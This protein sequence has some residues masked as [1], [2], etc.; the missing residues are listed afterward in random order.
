MA[1]RQC[2]LHHSVTCIWL[3]N[4]L[5]PQGTTKLLVLLLNAKCEDWDGPPAWVLSCKIFCMFSL[6]PH[7]ELEWDGQ[8]KTIVD[9]EIAERSVNM[10]MR[11]SDHLGFAYSRGDF[12]SLLRY[13]SFCLRHIL[14]TLYRLI[15]LQ[16]FYYF[17]RLN[18]YLNPV[19]GSKVII[20]QLLWFEL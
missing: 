7:R 2:N 20:I 17:R 9:T 3:G 11:V 10:C 1:P 5:L 12:S 6:W 4:T 19:K 16:D 14:L 18:I 8:L 15:L 13:V